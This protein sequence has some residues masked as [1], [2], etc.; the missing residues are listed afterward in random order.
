M[1]NNYS[2][3]DSFEYDEVRASHNMTKVLT[4]KVGR[5]N[6]NKKLF[7]PKFTRIFK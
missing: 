1:P 6:K 2:F 3:G 4:G 7:K 5:K